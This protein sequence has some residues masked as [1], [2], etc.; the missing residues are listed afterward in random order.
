M[1]VQISSEEIRRAFGEL[2]QDIDGDISSVSLE[3]DSNDKR[4]LE[5]LKNENKKLKE[6]IGMTSEKRDEIEEMV[7][8]VLGYH[9][10]LMKESFVHNITAMIKHAVAEEREACA[11]IVQKTWLKPKYLSMLQHDAI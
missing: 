1:K 4:E 11:E 3:W 6:R 5:K 8:T 2:M 7:L 10:R 9:N